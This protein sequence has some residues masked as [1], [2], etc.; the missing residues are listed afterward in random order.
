MGLTL[1][2]IIIGS[3]YLAVLFGSDAEQRDI[4]DC[5]TGVIGGGPAA[6]NNVSMC[7]E[8]YKIGRTVMAVT[9]VI[10]WLILAC[11]CSF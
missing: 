8:L 11:A 3:F 2:S 10:Y 1:L 7:T 6:G 4:N 9:L 5:V